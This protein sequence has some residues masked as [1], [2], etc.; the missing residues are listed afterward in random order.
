MKLIIKNVNQNPL[1]I[2]QR[3]T[4]TTD[5][6]AQCKF[7]ERKFNPDRVEKHMRICRQIT[8]KKRKRRVWDGAK[9][10]VEGTVF[11]EFQY[12]RSKTPPIIKEWKKHGRRW[13][14]ESNQLREIAAINADV[15]NSS[16]S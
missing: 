9:R 8:K 4:Q 10:R 1:S 7:C 16:F 15:N 3:D 11:E 13:K 2:P 14:D 12:N 6:R 5:Y